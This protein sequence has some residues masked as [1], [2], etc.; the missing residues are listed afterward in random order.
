[1]TGAK[2]QKL[3]QTEMEQMVK[4]MADLIQKSVP[5]TNNQVS[6]P[7]PANMSTLTAEESEPLCP[8][9]QTVIGA[10]WFRGDYPVGHPKFGKL[11]KCSNP[12]H[13]AEIEK[14][15]QKISQMGPEDIKRRLEDIAV[16]DKNRAMILA[17][18]D[19]IAQ[20]YGWL[21]IHGGPGNA[22]SEVL[23]AIVNAFNYAGRGP[24]VYTSLGSILD[25]MRLTMSNKNNLEYYNELERLKGIKVLA[26][27]EMDKPKET[28]WMQD[29]RFHFLDARYIS[30][31]NELSVTVFA[32]QTDPKTFGDVLYDRIRDG[33]FEIVHNLAPSAR[34]QM[35]WG[36]K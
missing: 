18:R 21:Y 33:R 4:Q 30:A 19:I 9:C 28:D 3:N 20:G 17:A 14:R 8:E 31:V 23:K 6:T 36:K 1:M 15:V 13:H 10:G 11:I 32:G 16:N 24:A 26:I 35:K 12:F 34:A 27:D 29:F 5:L 7:I 2:Y 25:Y 22:K